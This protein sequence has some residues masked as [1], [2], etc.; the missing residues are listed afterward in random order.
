MI[1]F[2]NLS[3]SGHINPTLPIV[4]D[5]VRR[6]EVVTYF[7]GEPFKDQIEKTGAQ[8]VALGGRASASMPLGNDQIKRLPYIMAQRSPQTVPALLA[9]VGEFQPNL[10]VYNALHLTA[11]L[12]AQILEIPAVTF[13]PF[14]APL[15]RRLVDGDDLGELTRAADEGLAR[16]AASMGRPTLSLAQVLS[17]REPLNLVF[18]PKEFQAKSEEFD[19]SY[20][21]VGPV[22][23]M[24][25]AGSWPFG[26]R[27][28]DRPRRLYVSLGTL[29]NDKPEFYRCCLKA[30][31]ASDWEVVMSVG[32]STD[33]SGLGAIPENFRVHPSVPQLALLAHVDAF[34]TH[35][36][37]N[38]V[39]E[40]V[41]L[42][43]PV[44]V[45]PEIDEQRLTAARVEELGLGYRLEHGSFG[46]DDLRQC[47]DRLT[48]DAMVRERVAAMRRLAVT[49]G[50]FRR[51]S[52]A[53]VNL[54]SRGSD[55]GRS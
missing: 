51:A 8:Y 21:F 14:H 27:G 23:D 42:G 54:K 49:A 32:H 34:I 45:V 3:A 43:V 24:P 53:I 10:L 19:K 55:L 41:S 44:V 7:A 12:V 33:I 35:G 31:A 26:D 16:L 11:R 50:G 36:G 22:L 38:S 5:L 20:L 47:V 46:A 30:F 4:Q 2:L 25:Q 52:E 9:R 37:L 18:V 1:V 29:R 40:S 17:L 13:R 39:M 6:G 28:A 48:R 15:T